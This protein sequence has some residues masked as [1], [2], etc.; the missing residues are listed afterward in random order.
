M[1][2]IK[3]IKFSVHYICPIFF[4]FTIGCGTFRGP[5]KFIGPNFKKTHSPPP[6]DEKHFA[7]DKIS[8]KDTNN[9]ND[10]ISESSFRWPVDKFS[11]SRGF[12]PFKK[13][14]HYGI[15]LAGPRNSKIK[16]IQNGRVFY[17]GNQFRGYGNVVMIAHGKVWASLYSHLEK[18]KVTENQLVKKGQTIGLM[19]ETGRTTGVHLH[20]E[21]RKNKKPIDP[22][23]IITKQ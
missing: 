23:K 14:P 10:I 2:N 21:L 5:G 18:I 15:D 19:G 22:E 20:F 17:A 16:S 12:M 6:I 4:L 13:R 8:K 3:L 1:L 7:S 9:K 11:K